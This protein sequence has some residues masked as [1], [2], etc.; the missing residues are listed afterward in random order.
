[1]VSVVLGVRNVLENPQLV[2]VLSLLPHALPLLFLE[3]S[4]MCVRLFASLMLF[5][6]SIF[7]PFY[8]CILG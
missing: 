4:Y 2:S 3:L 7:H 8:A 6:V 5:F 1:M